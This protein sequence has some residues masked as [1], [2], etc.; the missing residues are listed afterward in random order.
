MTSEMHEQ[1]RRPPEQR[2]AAA[3]PATPP[4]AAV[5]APQLQGVAPTTS[6]QASEAGASPYWGLVQQRINSKWI[7]P[8][9]DLTQR[10]LQVVIRFRMDRSGKV[11]EVVVVQSSGNDYFD[12]AGKR[13][14]LAADPLPP[15]P[16][17]ITE[18]QLSPKIFFTV[19]EQAG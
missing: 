17:E 5:S 1:I 15:F 16:V 12:N 19:G 6:I 7:A 11:S 18:R 9:V 3:R 8:P 4:S 13:A 10:F 14:V 2:L